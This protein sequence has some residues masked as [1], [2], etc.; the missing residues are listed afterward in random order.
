MDVKALCDLKG[1]FHGGCEA[2]AVAE[3][4]TVLLEFGL[5]GASGK[6]PWV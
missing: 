1:Q 5:C 4:G 2:Y 3:G 6:F